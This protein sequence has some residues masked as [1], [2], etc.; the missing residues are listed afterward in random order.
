VPV[1]DKGANV[2]EETPNKC[3]LFDVDGTLTKPRQP[4]ET[5]FSSFFEKWMEDKDVFLVSGSDLPKILEQ[6]P[7]TIANKCKGIFSCMGNEFWEQDRNKEFCAVYKNELILPKAI[8][9]WLDEK[10]KDSEFE[11]KSWAKTPPHFEY[12]GGMV[13]FSVVGRGASTALRQY[14]SEWDEGVKERHGIAKEF[15]EA[16]N[17]RYRLQALVGGQISLDIQQIGKDKGQI[18]D[19]LEY[20]EYVFFGDKCEKGGNDYSLYERA[21]EKWAVHSPKETFR[22]LK[23]CVR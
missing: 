4:M 13:N 2:K 21:T 7:S 6:I 8:K 9:K 17:K 3:F 15:N 12:R 20:G 14:Y 22:L 18:I 1:N 11:R 19:H 10:I 16:F 23:N 5:D